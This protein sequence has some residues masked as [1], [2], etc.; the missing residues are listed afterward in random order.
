M[1][2]LALQWLAH[3]TSTAV[4]ENTT[5]NYILMFAILT[6]QA[7]VRLLNDVEGL[8]CPADLKTPISRLWTWSLEFYSIRRHYCLR[9]CALKF[10][11]LC[12]LWRARK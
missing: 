5:R 9:K 4:D 12:G 2:A 8:P 6:R 3:D 11:L 10:T 7:R 1:L